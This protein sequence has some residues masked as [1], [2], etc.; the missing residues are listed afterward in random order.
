MREV[1]RANRKTG[2]KEKVLRPPIWTAHAD[3]IHPFDFVG[4]AMETKDLN[5]DVMLE[6]KAKDLA[7]KRLRQDILRYAPELQERFD[8]AGTDE[9][10]NEERV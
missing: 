7:L 5:F 9:T 10:C 6:A 8:A 1:V 4:F 2:K 3:Y